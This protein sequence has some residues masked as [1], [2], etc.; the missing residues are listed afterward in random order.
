DPRTEDY[1]LALLYI[2]PPMVDVDPVPILRTPF[3]DSVV[4]APLRIVGY[5]VSVI[6]D[7]STDGTKHQGATHLAADLASAFTDTAGPRASGRGDSG[8]PAL[9]MVAG[10]EYLAGITSRGDDA[11]TGFGVKTRVD[12]FAVSFIDPYVRA[13]LPGGTSPGGLCA[14]DTQCGGN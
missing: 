14:S 13:T 8:G 3:D 4:G 9:L 10:V 1:D 5:G 6:S 7:P 2:D 12:P 11:C